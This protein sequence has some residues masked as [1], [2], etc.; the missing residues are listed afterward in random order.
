MLTIHDDYSCDLTA[1]IGEIMQR[2]LLICLSCKLSVDLVT[3]VLR[4]TYMAQFYSGDSKFF[5]WKSRRQN[6]AEQ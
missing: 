3:H 6:L 2:I 4:R 1:L 5:W